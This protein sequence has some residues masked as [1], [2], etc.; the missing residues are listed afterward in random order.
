MNDNDARV[1]AAF[2]V[3]GLIGAGVAL[4]YAPKSGQETRKDIAK[5]A[6]K[7]KKEAV[8]IVEDTIESVNDF[9]GDVKDK[10][11]DIIERGVEF[12]DG[13]KKELIRSLE[14]G[15]KIIEKQK[16]RIIEGLG[17]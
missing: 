4:L 14:H 17:L 6:R 10:A 16:K 9:V 5:A 15:Q 12:S 3:G 2:L 1:A 7:V 13:A 11:G 8:E